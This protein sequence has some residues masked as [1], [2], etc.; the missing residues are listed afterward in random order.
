MINGHRTADGAVPAIGGRNTQTALCAENDGVAGGVDVHCPGNAEIEDDVALE[1]DKRSGKVVHA[2]RIGIFMMLAVADIVRIRAEE[3]GLI[4]RNGQRLRIA[5]RVH[6][7][8]Q[9]IAA[10]V[11]QSADAAG[12]LCDEGRTVGRRDTATTTA[13]GLDVIDLAELARL[14][15]LFDHLHVGIKTRL[16]ADR[17][18]L[19]A[20]FLGFQQ[21]GSLV[22]GDAHRLLQQDVDTLFKRI[23]CRRNVLTVVGADGDRIQMHV[24]IV[25]HFLVAAVI[26][27]DAL[28]TQLLAE[29]SRLAG[30][31]VRRSDDLGIR[32]VLIRRDVC[33]CNPARADDTDAQ[34]A[35]GIHHFCF[36]GVLLEAVENI[37]HCIYLQKII[38]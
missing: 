2:E 23:D 10:D 27:L 4:A 8:V 5:D 12:I 18:H 15:N 6:D 17:Q 34:L 31:D 14:N 33:F 16:E 24:R 21:F 28:K 32:I 26:A 13:A 36:L 29:R 30:D 35:V 7:H 37:A 19:A 11:A 9:R 22:H 38:Y 1:T 25:Q 3:R 20:L